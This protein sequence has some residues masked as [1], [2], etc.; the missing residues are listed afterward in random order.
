M[1]RM[2]AAWGHRLDIMPEKGG[3]GVD[4]EG[5]GWKEDVRVKCNCRGPVDNVSRGGQEVRRVRVRSRAITALGL[6]SRE[7]KWIVPHPSRG[8]VENRTIKLEP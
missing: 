1:A 3:M 2:K 7:W 8:Y 4:W 5:G 6:G